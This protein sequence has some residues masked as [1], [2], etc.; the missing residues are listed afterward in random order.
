MATVNTYFSDFLKNIRLSGNQIKDLAKGHNTL[1]SRL[2]EDE[3]LSKIIETTYLQG[4]YKRNTAV[5]PRNGK[6][7]D[8]DIIVVTNLNSDEIA[9]DEALEKFKPFLE[10]YYKDKYDFH[11]R[12]IGIELSYVDL[13]LVITAKVQD[14]DTL[15]FMKNEERNVTNGLQS[16]IESEAYNFSRLD[17]LILNFESKESKDPTP[18]LIPDQVEN[19]WSLTNPL[20]QINWTIEKNK[21]CNGNYINVVKTLKWWKKHHTS[22]K[23]PK[24]YP[25]EH[26]IGQVCPNDI[27][28]VAE[29]LTVSLENIVMEYP[30]KPT[31]FD[32][33]VDSHDVFGRVTEDE[34]EEFYKL[35]EDAAKL[36]RKA[37][38]ET[39]IS[40]SIEY[41][42]ELLGTEFPEPISPKTSNKTFTSRMSLTED[43]GHARFG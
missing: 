42:R 33:G 2:L 39:N 3:E 18:I 23:Y 31:L 16:M 13:D 20:A 37:L 15:N 26:L 9:P 7:S 40:S 8:V 6:R 21:N 32:H 38:D 22:P 5:K 11:Q 28:T 24:G 25:L 36:A 27:K 43:I 14:S 19:N 35:I 4:S 1:R 34:Y 30:T 17:N 10:K 41:W 12:S 29:G